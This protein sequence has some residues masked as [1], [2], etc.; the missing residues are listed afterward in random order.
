M[1]SINIINIA[2]V[3]FTKTFTF[4]PIGFK[5]LILHCNNDR[6]L[7]VILHEF[8]LLNSEKTIYS[9]VLKLLKK[10]NQILI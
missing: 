1:K 3:N 6:S 2:Q 10:H 9:L 8:I 5:S 7:L 4:G